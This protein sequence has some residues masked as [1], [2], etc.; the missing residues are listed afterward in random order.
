MGR[1]V[2]RMGKIALIVGVTVLLAAIPLLL[3]VRLEMA[4]PAH[5]VEEAAAV[6]AADLDSELHAVLAEGAEMPPRD[7]SPPLPVHPSL[8]SAAKKRKA[9]AIRSSSETPPAAPLDALSAPQPPAKKP[10]SSGGGQAHAAA[11]SGA[12]AMGRVAVG[13]PPPPPPLPLPPPPPSPRA[14]HLPKVHATATNAAATTTAA[15]PAADE[16]ARE[17]SRGVHVLFSTDCSP[18]QNWQAVVLF[19][20][21]AAAGQ[22]GPLT[23]IASGCSAE[24]QASLAAM[25]AELSPQFRVHF[26]P[27]FSRDKKTGKKYL[28]FNKPRGLQHWAAAHAGKDANETVV[29]LLD[30]DMLLLRPI[31]G[32]FPP[33]SYLTSPD[34]KAGEAWARVEKGR[35]AGQQYGLGALWRSFKREYICGEGSPCLGVSAAEANKY[36][37]VGPPY[38]LHVSDVARLAVTWVD[39]APRIYEEYPELLAEM[40]AYCMASAH[41]GLRHFKVDHLMVSNVD[42]GGEGWPWVDALTRSKDDGPRHRAGALAASESTAYAAPLLARAAAAAPAA[43]VASGAGVAGA[44]SA[45]TGAAAGEESRGGRHLAVFGG[46]MPA[47]LHLC[48]N[49]RL[50]DWLFAKR[51]VPKVSESV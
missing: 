26:T 7:W 6:I 48:Q 25:H 27:D 1:N 11:A 4:T 15:A 23:R 35:P 50:G 34:W 49:Y 29:A 9:S 8:L 41:L 31:T 5:E 22:R 32:N 51:R 33:G 19:Y 28:F 47:T 17:A 12:G 43:A 46:P 38:L 24:E 21:A 16:G 45:A 36:F 37:P 30:P 40:Y 18:F 39:F 13:A 3:I 42:A 10:Q 44:D 2:K 20:S 14:A